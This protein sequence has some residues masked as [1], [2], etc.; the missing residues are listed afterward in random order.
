[1]V[2]RFSA[3]EARLKAANAQKTLEDQ[4]KRNG[5][6]KKSIAKERA[7]I[8]QGYQQQKVDVISAAIDGKTEIVVDSIYLYKELRVFG[9]QVVEEGLVKK[10]NQKRE[11]V[12]DVKVREKIKDEILEHFD[13]FIDASKHDLKGYYGG[14]QRFHRQN[15]DALFE[16]INSDWSWSEFYGDEVYSEE[17]PDDL[18]SKYFDYFEKINEKIKEFIACNED[19]DFEENDEEDYDDGQLVTGEYFFSDEDY[20]VDLLKPSIK[21]NTLKIRWT[22]EEGS[23]YMNDPL[24]SDV[25]LAWLSTYRGQ[26]LI[27]DIFY[28]LSSAAEMGKTNLKLDFSLTKEGWSFVIGSRKVFC[29]MPDELVEIIARENFTIEDTTSTP[30]SYAIKVSW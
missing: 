21:G 16:I 26:K 8:K 2:T 7:F 28:S 4:R 24:L 14:L 23:T 19:L 6:L 1:M 30:K 17:V 29:C 9:I 15:Y 18:K 25:G 12:F 3:S 10:Q 13:T 11:K 27:E 22:A 5:E 20:G